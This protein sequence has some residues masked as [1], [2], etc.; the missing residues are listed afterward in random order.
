MTNF[1]SGKH[2]YGH[3][4][5]LRVGTDLVAS[6]M[7]GLGSGYL[8]DQWLGTRPWFLLLFFLFGAAAGFLNLYV[9]MGL[10]KPKDHES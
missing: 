2:G 1:K 10:D 5:G 9:I 7:V 8:L 4:W 3:R 6:T